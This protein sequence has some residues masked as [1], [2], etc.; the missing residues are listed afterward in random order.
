MY[1]DNDSRNSNNNVIYVRT[2]IHNIPLSICRYIHICICIC[3]CVYIYIYVYTYTYFNGHSSAQTRAL[4]KDVRR[5]GHDLLT[6]VSHWRSLSHTHTHTNTLTHTLGAPSRMNL[7]YTMA[8]A[9][10][11]RRGG[12]AS[13]SVGAMDARCLAVPLLEVPGARR[14]LIY[15]YIYIYIHTYM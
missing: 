12:R 2:H 8:Q 5:S 6:I 9:A 1:N 14:G 13:C 11:R 7:L 4:H 10:R 3:I 15:I